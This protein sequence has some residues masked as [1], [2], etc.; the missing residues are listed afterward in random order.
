VDPF[1]ASIKSLLGERYGALR[2]PVGVAPLAHHFMGGVK[3]DACGR[4]SVPG[5]FAAGEVCGGLHGANRMG[6]NALAETLV[7]G[8]RAG[9][10]AAEWVEARG[11]KRGE[12]A[13][14]KL[15]DCTSAGGKTLPG[16]DPRKQL[17]EL[18]K[19]MWEDG[20][21]VRSEQGLKRALLAVEA[22]EE[23]CGP[24]RG[25]PGG[26]QGEE[27]MRLSFAARTARLVLKGALRR[28]ESR[29][30]HFREDF[31]SQNDDWRGHLQVRSNLQGNLEWDF[32]PV[33]QLEAGPSRAG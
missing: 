20:G 6:G 14:E 12:G 13:W 18:R 24:L 5:L 26:P 8:A 15:R 27:L 7:F 2:R 30:A 22:V 31:P 28:C 33:A 25:C 11:E 16:S 10:A 19:I 21:I 23:E 9:N 3:I 32:E 1:S 29:G 17:D 4:T